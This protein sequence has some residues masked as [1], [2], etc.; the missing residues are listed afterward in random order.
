M[1]VQQEAAKGG[2]RLRKM[3]SMAEFDKA[4]SEAG[5][6]ENF[7]AIW[8]RAG[9]AGDVQEQGAHE[10]ALR[11]WWRRTRRFPGNW[12]SPRRN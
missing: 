6:M 7:T 8:S 5:G 12:R 10:G 1:V 2:L 3:T 11:N 4:V 9:I